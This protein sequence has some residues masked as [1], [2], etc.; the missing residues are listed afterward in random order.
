MVSIPA[1][2]FA[3]MRCKNMVF[4]AEDLAFSVD[5]LVDDVVPATGFNAVRL[6]VP[7]RDG[8][9]LGHE[10]CDSLRGDVPVEVGR[11]E[12]PAKS[13]VRGVDELERRAELPGIRGSRR[14]GLVREVEAVAGLVP[15]AG[16]RVVGVH[17][18]DCDVAAPH[19]G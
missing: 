3:T 6:L 2:V 1:K 7:R 4:D 9:H 15:Y 5:V 16:R 12:A 13:A 10:V 19:L 18:P 17:V 14:P 11:K 8:N